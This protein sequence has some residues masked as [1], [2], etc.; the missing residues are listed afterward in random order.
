MFATA[1]ILPKEIMLS[2]W[3]RPGGFQ[4]AIPWDAAASDVIWKTKLDKIFEIKRTN[5][6]E[7]FEKSLKVFCQPF[8]YLIFYW[9][10]IL[11][12]K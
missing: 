2:V 4:T 11:M 1:K 5:K 10:Q 8:R 3:R 9:G 12:D 7:E 6:N